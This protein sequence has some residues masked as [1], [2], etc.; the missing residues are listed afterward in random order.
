MYMQIDYIRVALSLALS[1]AVGVGVLYALSRYGVGRGQ[2]PRPEKRIQV[3]DV[4]PLGNRT[5][6][7]AVAFGGAEA[8]L[9]VGPTFAC[10]AVQT[11]SPPAST[12]SVSALTS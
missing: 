12:Q 2:K 3:I 9:V 11:A 10:V 8:L 4:H 1:V 6:L 7:V 5:S